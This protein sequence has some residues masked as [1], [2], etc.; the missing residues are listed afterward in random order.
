MSLLRT[1][2]VFGL[3]INLTGTVFGD[4]APGRG[5]MPKPPMIAPVKIVEDKV[6]YRDP[7][8]VA[9]IIIPQSLL[10]EM[11]EGSNRSR[12]SSDSRSIGTIIAGL[13]LTAAAISLIFVNRTDPRQKKIV[14]AGIGCA[15]IVGIVLANILF[16]PELVRPDA[17]PS[18]LQRLIVFEVQEFG[19]EVTLI[20]PNRK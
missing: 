17:H 10:S 6:D 1:L 14:A 15:L 11:Q 4:I 5:G 8:V 19:H 13:A 18:E 16:P 12:S 3:L 2:Y 7:N 9:K 20:L